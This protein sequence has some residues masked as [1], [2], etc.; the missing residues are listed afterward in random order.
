M[1]V[2]LA[3]RDHEF[4]E[5]IVQVMV[6]AELVLHPIPADVAE[7]V[8][9][10]ARA[11]GVEEN[12][13]RV[14]RRYAAGNLGLAAHDLRRTG[15]LSRWDDQ[16]AR[17]LHTKTPPA[18]PFDIS[19]HD[20]ELYE[21]WAAFEALPAG[22]LGRAVWQFYV[23]RGFVFPGH[24]ESAPPYL[25]QHDFVH[26]LADYC[27]RLEGEFEV[28]GMIGR[29]D[30]DPRGFTWIATIIGLFETGYHDS[31]GLFVSDVSHEL[32]SPLTR[33]TARRRLPRASPANRPGTERTETPA[34]STH[35]E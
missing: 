30:P 34:P 7:R 28:F 18:D 6:L 33:K 15:Y 5:R 12:L 23:D 22:S 19:C 10:Y 16:R 21:R 4:H 9:D 1:A 14:A 31:Q 25:A 35:P 32:R 29:A 8:D 24:P 17:P 13:V 2:A 3:D 11:L 27:S 26:V 20:Q